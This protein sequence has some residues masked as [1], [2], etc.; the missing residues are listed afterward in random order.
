MADITG[1]TATE[2]ISDSID[3]VLDNGDHVEVWGGTI[4]E[5]LDDDESPSDHKQEM[6]EYTDG[7][8][9]KLTDPLANW[10][11]WSR[12][13]PGITLRETEDD[14]FG[15]NPGM[16][17]QY[18]KVYR[19]SGWLIDKNEFFHRNNNTQKARQETSADEIYPHT[20]GRRMRHF[21]ADVAGAT[22]HDQWEHVADMIERHPNTRKA[23]MS[24]S[25]PEVDQRLMFQGDDDSA[26][27]PCNLTFQLRVID[28]KLNWTTFSR[29]K[30]ILRG[31]TENL[32]EFPL[33]QQLMVAELNSRGMDV[34]VGKYVEQV[35]NIHIYQ[36]QID[37][38]YLEQ[39]I[40]DP[41]DYWDTRQAP[42][43]PPQM[44]KKID[45]SLRANNWEQTLERL[46]RIDSDYWRD[47]KVT[48][49]AE[50]ARLQGDKDAHGELWSMLGDCEWRVPVAKRA[51]EQW[52]DDWYLQSLPDPIV[53]SIR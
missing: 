43:Q 19:E 25:R 2:V 39:D 47:W 33:L 27:V 41:Y 9:Y 10:S 44:F 37:Q 46:E 53:N 50:W 12:H 6:I 48:L 36:D 49:A 18:S 34:E 26:Y 21:G 13:W 22:G 28:G 7:F 15:L 51:Y 17:P 35:S 14:L 4:P 52:E 5:D 3:F 38:G 20:Y 40:V 24:F 1:D 45:Y 29:S 30:D 42:H 8:S 31:S 23:V 16:T 11:E 32:F